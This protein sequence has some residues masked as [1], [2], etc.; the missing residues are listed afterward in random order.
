MTTSRYAASDSTADRDLQLRVLEVLE[1]ARNYN[2]WITSLIL[3]HL[4]EYPVELGSGLG[5]QTELLLRAGLRRVSVSEPTPEGVAALRDRFAGDARVDCCVIDFTEAPARDHSAAYAVNV[6]EHVD[7]DVAALTG[8]ARL[9]RRGGKVVVFVPAFPVAMSKFD[10][11][12]GHH[13][14]YTRATLRAAVVAA[15]L[16]PEIVR[17]VNAPGLPVWLVWMRLLGRRPKEGLALTVWDRLVV[18]VARAV[19]RRVEPPFGQSILAVARV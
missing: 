1:N 12:L 5:Y 4:G 2:S 18:P 14:R 7:D 11:E 6:L 3:P 19:E 8:A 17:Y 9:V 10:R 13:R 15:G 16:E